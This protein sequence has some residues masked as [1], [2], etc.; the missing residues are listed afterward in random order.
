MQSRSRLSWYLGRFELDG[1]SGEPRGGTPQA[2]IRSQATYGTPHSNRATVFTNLREDK[3]APARRIVQT[4]HRVPPLHGQGYTVAA[5]QLQVHHVKRHDEH[6]G[7]DF[8][9]IR[10]RSTCT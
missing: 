7:I 8:Y 4:W 6:L 3:H 5:R 2:V 9:A 1:I 10:W